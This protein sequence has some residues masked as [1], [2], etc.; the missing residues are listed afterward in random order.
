[1]Q[2]FNTFAKIIYFFAKFQKNNPAGLSAGLKN[3]YI[4]ATP[5]FLAASATALETVAATRSSKGA[6]IT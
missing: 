6:G 4:L 2:I 3:R 5:V 1:M